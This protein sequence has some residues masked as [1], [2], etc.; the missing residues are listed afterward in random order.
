M[1]KISIGYKFRSSS[2]HR[3]AWPDRIV[4]EITWVRLQTFTL[5]S[6]HID[7]MDNKQKS[8]H[9]REENNVQ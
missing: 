3:V 1:K 7:R 6:P 8:E 2:A 9:E 4:T 5:S